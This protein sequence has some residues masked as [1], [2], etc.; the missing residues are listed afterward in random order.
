V[1]IKGE[2][3]AVSAGH[4][5]A[6]GSKVVTLDPFGILPARG[7]TL[8]RVG[9]NP[10]SALDPTAESFVDDAMAIAEALIQVNPNAKDPHWT[11]SAQ[12][13]VAALVMLVRSV[14]AD[15]AHLGMVRREI[16]RSAAEIELIA[17]E[18]MKAELHP[19]IRNKMAKFVDSTDSK[20]IPS[21]LSTAHGTCQRL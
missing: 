3:A 15:A 5:A 12:D 10:L 6:K 9:F 20:E 16:S 4:R 18:V 14:S 17:R 2:L 1:D 13:F 19:A 21:I 8:P 11:E 7:V